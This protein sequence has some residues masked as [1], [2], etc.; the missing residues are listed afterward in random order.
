MRVKYVDTNMC[1][2]YVDGGEVCTLCGCSVWV[3]LKWVSRWS[4]CS[5]WISY[6]SECEVCG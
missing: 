1:V 5:V 4:G 6:V 3:K 2:K